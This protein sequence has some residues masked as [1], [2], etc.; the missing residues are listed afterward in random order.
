MRLSLAILAILWLLIGFAEPL[1]YWLLAEGN[2]G[3][4][5]SFLVP[6]AAYVIGSLILAYYASTIRLDKLIIRVLAFTGV[7][8]VS[9][10][11]YLVVN[12]PYQDDWTLGGVA[13]GNDL[14][15][16]PIERHLSTAKQDGFN[17]LV[18]LALAGCDYCLNTIDDLILIKQRHPELDLAIFVFAVDSAEIKSIQNQIGENGILV[19]DAPEPDSTYR[20]TYGNFPTLLLVKNGKVDYK[21]FYS[22]F[23]YPAKDLVESMAENM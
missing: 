21:W 5:S 1:R 10:S 14:N 16:K 8:T 23:G 4:F 9:V 19:A 3:W 6:Q 17:G 7:L 18:C 2:M 12:P 15:I 11:A 20:I 22:Q 13:A